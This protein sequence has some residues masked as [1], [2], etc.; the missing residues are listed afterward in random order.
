MKSLGINFLVLAG[1]LGVGVG[2][3][4]AGEMTAQKSEFT[5]NEF[6]DSSPLVRTFGIFRDQPIGV[7]SSTPI[8]VENGEIYTFADTDSIVGSS[9]TVKNGGTFTFEGGSI[10]SST[11]CYFNQG[12]TLNA[13]NGV[14]TNRAQNIMT[15]VT[16]N[17]SGGEI[18]NGFQDSAIIGAE[19][20]LATINVSGSGEFYNGNRR[21]STGTIHGYVNMSGGQF[22]NGTFNS[23]FSEG[24]TGDGAVGVITKNVTI[25]GGQFSNGY[26]LGTS[27][28]VNGNVIVNGGTFINGKL[29]GGQ[30][31]INGSVTINAGSL[32][33]AS[34]LSNTTLS[35]N[36][37]TSDVNSAYIHNSGTI[38]NTAIEVTGGHFHNFTGGQITGGTYKVKANDTANWGQISST[39]ITVDGGEFYNTQAIGSDPLTSTNGTITGGSIDVL[40]NAAINWGTINGTAITLNGDPSSQD[41]A[42]FKNYASVQNA[43]VTV[44]AGI[45][46]NYKYGILEN[47]DL[48][49]TKHNSFNWGNITNTDI[50]ISGGFFQNRQAD[51]TEGQTDSDGVITGGTINISATA[52]SGN[53]A[54]LVNYTSI[55][56]STINI[57]DSKDDIAS[58]ES[59]MENWN[60]M[61]NV[62]ITVD[63][64][65]QNNG[66]GGYFANFKD[67]TLKN[68]T[69]KLDYRLVINWGTIQSTNVTINGGDFYN[70]SSEDTHT[71]TQGNGS[72]IGGTVTVNGGNFE[73]NA[74]INGTTFSLSAGAYDHHRVYNF[75]TITD[76]AMTIDGGHIYNHASGTIT[77]GS[78]DINANI[79]RNDGTVDGTAITL[80][81]KAD[82]TMHYMHNYGSVKNATITFNG[83]H[84][85]TFAGS[86]IT[87]GSLTLNKG[88]FYNNT[89]VDGT[90]I[91]LSPHESTLNGYI[92]NHST[93]TNSGITINGGHILNFTA[94]TITGSTIDFGNYNDNGHNINNFGNIT[95]CNITMNG[96]VFYNKIADP[97]LVGATGNGV[98]TGGTLTL[99][100]GSRFLFE[101]GTV[102]VETVCTYNSGSI[103]EVT[104]GVYN[105]DSGDT[106]NGATLNV[107]GSEFNNGLTDS[108]VL[109]SE[110]DPA[111]LNINSYATFYNARGQGSAGLIWGNISIQYA[112]FHNGYEGDGTIGSASNRSQITME[113]MTFVNGDQA[114]ATG[115]IYGDID[116]NGG[117]F[118][119]SK[120]TTSTGI[121]NGNITMRD[122]LFFNGQGNGTI[123]GDVTINNLGRFVN[124]YNNYTT[125]A[126]ATDDITARIVSTDSSNPINVTINDGTIFF[127]GGNLEFTLGGVPVERTAG[128][129]YI[130]GN[131]IHNSTSAFYNGTTKVIQGDTTK[132]S[133]GIIEGNVTQNNG[134]FYNGYDNSTT[135]TVTG[136]V[137]LTQNAIN[138]MNG[139]YGNGTI[140]SADS[141]STITIEGGELTSGCYDGSLGTIYGDVNVT[142]STGRFLNAF[143]GTATMHGDVTTVGSFYNGTAGTT[144]DQGQVITSLGTLN[145]NVIQNGGNVYNGYREG[146]VGIINGNV[147]VTAGDFHNGSISNSKGTINGNIKITGGFFYNGYKSSG[148]IGSASSPSTITIEGGELISGCYDGS[149]GT[150]HGDVNVTTSVGRFFNAY[151][152]TSVMNGNVN[153]TGW[154][155][156]GAAGKTTDQGQVITSLGT[157]NGN[158][159][160][161]GGYAFNGYREGGVGIINGNV[162]ITGGEFQ[163]GAL[164]GAQGTINGTVTIT[165][166]NFRNSLEATTTGTING[167]VVIGGATSSA[168]FYSNDSRAAALSNATFRVKNNGKFIAAVNSKVQTFTFESGSIFE[169]TLNEQNSQLSAQK[170]SSDNT[171]EIQNGTTVV[172]MQGQ[173]NTLQNEQNVVIANAESGLTTDITQ[174][175]LDSS[176]FDET[177]FQLGFTL[178]ADSKN[179]YISYSR[180]GSYE[181]IATPPNKE[182]AKTIDDLIET[183]DA[184]EELEK[185]IIEMDQTQDSLA[186]NNCMLQ[187]QPRHQKYPYMNARITS[188]NASRNLGQF[189]VARRLALR[190]APYKLSIDPTDTGFANADNSALTRNALAQ[191]LPKPAGERATD[192]EVGMDKIVSIYGRATTGYTSVGASDERIGLRAS[193]VGALVGFD[194]R[195]H[196]NVIIGFA[197][198]YDYSD[199]NYLQHLGNGQVNSYRFG[200]YAMVYAG[201]W[202]FQ[203]EANI[204]LHDNKF[205]RRVNFTNETAKSE[206][207][208]IDFSVGLG[209]GFDIDLCGINITP[210]LNLQYQFYH[211]GAFDEKEAPG[212][213]L[214]VHRYDTSAI[215]SRLGVEIWKRFEFDSNMMRSATP[216]FNIGWRKEWLAATDLTS[217]FLGGGAAFNIDNDLYSRNAIYLGI[218]STFELSDSLNLDLR[219]QADLG[220]RENQTQNASLNLRY[221]F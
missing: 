193:R 41:S 155:Y 145:G 191:V 176:D 217:Q 121:I 35:I 54:A 63:G 62:N 93:I 127:N 70:Q 210:S 75:G 14:F 80:I 81:Y 88:R 206:Y 215:S 159:T 219:Y 59:Y 208:A 211:A 86:S 124:G 209:A 90:T 202:F 4:S 129:G 214:R 11:T 142:T 167:D 106:F 160:Q 60:Q 139:Y 64:D 3:A 146:G 165:S 156:N 77:G 33:N 123:N 50:T 71:G 185:I 173:I 110:T 68:S 5:S 55:S 101:G 22:Y 162:E 136:N 23:S 183:G 56:G 73:N 58:T 83:G 171:G 128:H 97:N 170:I 161:T 177:M 195:V 46:K 48:T 200:P 144:T 61:E 28:T 111:T 91:I 133:S 100:S 89:S 15:Q 178:S 151:E 8:V 94:G 117:T 212:A 132:N 26:E 181:D 196:E 51:T 21:G 130:K 37:D 198:S 192:R 187:L 179:L 49:I 52:D 72:I 213:A 42:I 188:I 116:Q 218:G 78:I 220:D 149:L 141:P 102:S 154:F 32:E 65:T 216:F 148:T 107:S 34:T 125:D 169:T 108:A 10:S 40:Q 98:I 112:S 199:V 143:E 19:T 87:G 137:K 29:A 25:T 76:S 186:K 126:P 69:I 47:S 204:G 95:N 2:V 18:N 79:F 30:G 17:L 120:D 104:G 24:L 96:G 31:T 114:N 203:A 152:S 180:A 13:T 44:N 39:A 207:D 45:L 82:D 147:T 134:S 119:N 122:G 113:T 9:I 190:G 174:L 36:G 85:F 157:L 115:N 153:T 109:G 38:Q 166:G 182:I 43:N 99:N 57:Y 27:G 20:N 221:R 205:G 67:A 53:I 163:N 131:V 7:L 168:N 184:S 66:N 197:G 12:S 150:I 16:V 1:I 172:I 105:H 164:S 74:A 92:H 84:L 103:L 201:N 189:L 135:G 158:V 194:V 118:Y 6:S 175:I 138:F 140:G